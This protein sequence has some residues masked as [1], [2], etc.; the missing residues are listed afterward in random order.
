[1]MV[2]CEGGGALIGRAFVFFDVDALR[3]T[4]SIDLT[5][6]LPP[7]LLGATFIAGPGES[8]REY[9]MTVQDDGRVL[10]TFVIGT[11]A[12]FWSWVLDVTD[13]TPGAQ[14]TLDRF[15]P[16]PLLGGRIFKF[17]AL[18]TKPIVNPEFLRGFRTRASLQP[19]ASSSD[20]LLALVAGSPG[21]ATPASVFVLSKSIWA[22]PPPEI[23]FR[24]GLE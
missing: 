9:D 18:N 5:L 16:S 17:D 11:G 8:I 22:G 20:A 21:T 23:I 12:D 4:P 3:N 13:T 6:P 24:N 7:A 2:G 10:A 14:I 15:N 19:S 1:M